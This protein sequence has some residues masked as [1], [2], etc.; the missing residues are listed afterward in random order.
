MPRT[1][2]L[3]ELTIAEYLDLLEAL[4]FVERNHPD[5]IITRRHKELQRKL[6]RSST[7]GGTDDEKGK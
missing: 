2:K 1:V 5:R 3:P 6:F 4:T 7:P